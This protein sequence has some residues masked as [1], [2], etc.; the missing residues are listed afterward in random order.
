MV[1]TRRG[2]ASAVR[3]CLLW[4]SFLPV[5]PLGLAGIFLSWGATLVERVAVF[6]D[7]QNVHNGAHRQFCDHGTQI[8]EALVHP[9]RLGQKIVEKRSIKRPSE[10]AAVRVFRGRPNP[11]HQPTPTA[12]NDA[13]AYAW[14]QDEIV[15][16][17]R[18]DLNYRGWPEQ[19]ARE[20]GVDVA[21][22][23]SLVRAA[24]NQDFD[25][26]VVFSCDTDLLPALEM[27][28]YDTE[29]RLEIACWSGQ[30]TLW[31]PEERARGRN[32]PYCHFLN[33]EDFEA[34]RDSTDYLAGRSPGR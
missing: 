17:I 8:H 6:V 7:Y 23:I 14:E 10:L 13:Q 32:T 9:L 15:T 25:V 24:V 30:K 21:L 4:G 27:A 11:E 12:A 5:V 19:S 22:A 1:T 2:L 31:F 3:L 33:A 18:R 29:T 16:V 26:A 20:K 28:Y 34:V